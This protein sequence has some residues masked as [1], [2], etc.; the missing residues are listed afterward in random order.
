[1]AAQAPTDLTPVAV[2]GDGGDTKGV[3]RRLSH[4]DLLR[5]LPAEEM[6]HLLPH[7]YRVTIPAGAQVFEKGDAGD[8]L[9]IIEAGTAQVESDGT[10]EEIGVD[11]VLGEAALL[12]GDLH[13]AT[14]TAT[15]DLVLWRIAR[16][17]Y[18]TAF[19]HS[20]ELKAAHDEAADKHR[21]G[22]EL[23]PEGMHH[24]RAWVGTALRAA[25]AKRRGLEPWHFILLVGFGIWLL[26]RFN[27]ST[28][29]IAEESN[30]LLIAGVQLVAGLLLI[31][32]A[33]E[34]LILATDRT[35]ARFNWDGF[36]SGTIGSLVETM[37]EFF[38]I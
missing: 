37:P 8:A 31:E 9:Y 19:E 28:G 14:V 12:H 3:L 38:V 27:E 21:S 4:S 20:P 10:K 18:L 7:I 13:D 35:G 15:T 22:T 17:D 2:L 5:A 24:Q 11:D 33:S 34:A 36:T 16:A 25:A 29:W 30:E 32:A 1:M 6:D 23:T 26:L